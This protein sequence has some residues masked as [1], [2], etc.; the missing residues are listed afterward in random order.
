AGVGFWIATTPRSTIRCSPAET[1]G[2]PPRYL[3]VPREAA[4][5]LVPLGRRA[6]RNRP[7]Q[8]KYTPSPSPSPSPAS[9][10]LVR[11]VVCFVLAGALTL[12]A[13]VSDGL[14]PC[15][16]TCSLQAVVGVPVV[17]LL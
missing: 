1:C 6:Q 17:I 15:T 12:V 13:L 16:S 10:R 14:V 2:C 4:K 3:A 9:T 8:T 7:P 5:V 11:T